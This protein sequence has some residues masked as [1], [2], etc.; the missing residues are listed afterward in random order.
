M[1]ND[2]SLFWAKT[3]DD[4][5][6][7]ERQ[8]AFHPLICHLIDVAMAARAIW[9]NV[10]TDTQKKRLAKCFGLEN[11]LDKAG[12][13]TAFLI[14]LHDLGK[15]S[16][17]FAL[18][19]KYKNQ[20]EQTHR[21]YQLYK[22]S[23]FDMKTFCAASDARHE[24]VTSIVLPP[25][26][27][28][29]FNFPKNL[30][31]SV[32]N[33]IGGH[34][35]NFPTVNFQKNK[36]I[37]SVCGNEVWR[38]A[39]RELVEEL[40]DALKIERNFPNLE[41]KKIDNATAMIFAGFV[42]AADWVGS[43]ADFF[44]CE[45][46]DSTKTE[47]DENFPVNAE[48]YLEKSKLKALEALKKLGWLNWIPVTEEKKFEELFPLLTEPRHLQVV[49]QK[50]AKEI[51]SVGIVVVEEQMG[52]GKTET[53][54]FLA[55]VFNAVLKQRGIYFALPTQA[56]SNQMF[57]RVKDFLE[58]KHSGGK[59]NVQ[60]LLQHGHSSLSEEFAENVEDF[61][62][63]YGVFDET[64]T[65]KISPTS[66]PPNGSPTKN[67]GFSCRSGSARLTRF[68]SAFCRSNTF[69]CDCSDSRIKRLS[70]TKFTLTM[71]ICQP[72]SNACSNGSPRFGRRSSF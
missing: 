27:E 68:C 26:L 49:A 28:G 6:N 41:N 43:N 39:Q 51:D 31:E 47:Q 38:T 7:P 25:I 63:L 16:P 29:K 67:A 18:R 23:R 70:L 53:A 3:T 10:L 4:K 33:I 34:H 15:C 30:A 48:I 2:T 52:E 22:D 20:T 12:I 32:C 56:T 60:F 5:D 45:I 65:K 8:N 13:L 36:N 50:I 46:A 17:P 66:S 62:K 64:E 42:T 54:M 21:L 71:R 11:D 37:D 57:G 19:G 14:G 1:N 72:C 55:D 35:G 61:K 58:R 24:F 44:K 69:S 9:E 40:A 59:V